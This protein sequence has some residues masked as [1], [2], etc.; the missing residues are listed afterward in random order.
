[1]RN[2]CVVKNG[3]VVLVD[4]NCVNV[5]TNQTNAI[6]S[7]ED[8]H[9]DVDLVATRRGRTIIFT[10]GARTD[11]SITINM[12]GFNQ[13]EKDSNY[14]KFTTNYYDE[15]TGNDTQYESFGIRSVKATI[16][17]SFIPQVNIEFVD[18][19]GLSFFNQ[20]ADKIGRA[21]V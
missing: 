6:P 13:N 2:D 17:S 4:P 18:I 8:M 19:R 20:G 9:I 21:H 16:N 1:M 7:Y 10:G 3:N 14:E 11:K 5:N 15:S 12:M